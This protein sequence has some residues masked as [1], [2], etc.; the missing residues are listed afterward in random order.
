LW[1]V[2]TALLSLFYQRLS[3]F[4]PWGCYCVLHCPVVEKHKIGQW[5]STG[6]L[7]L[8]GFQMFVVHIAILAIARFGLMGRAASPRSSPRERMNYVCA[9]AQVG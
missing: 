7:Q 6:L 3:F 9:V 8:F 2:A 5:L 4:E 1:P